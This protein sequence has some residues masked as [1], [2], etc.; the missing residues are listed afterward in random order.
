MKH[1][2]M[3]VCLLLAFLFSFSTALQV[4]GKSLSSV[5]C[6]GSQLCFLVLS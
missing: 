4:P 3:A 2:A 5:E 6:E 1:L